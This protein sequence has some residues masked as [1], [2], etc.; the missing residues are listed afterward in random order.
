MKIPKSPILCVLTAGL[1]L[2]QSAGWSQ[3][4]S[5]PPGFGLSALAALDANTVVAVGSAILRT[6]D[7][8]ITWT[9]ASTAKFISAVSFCDA[10]TGSA[11]GAS[12]TILRTTDG[13]TTWTEQSSGTTRPLYGIKLL[14]ASIGVAVGQN[15]VILRTTDGG[16]TWN[17]VMVGGPDLWAISFADSQTGI[18]V[19]DMSLIRR[20]TD[21]GVTWKTLNNGDRLLGGIRAI[22]LT[23]G[24]TGIAMAGK[25]I[26][27]TT[28]GGLSWALHLSSNAFYGVFFTDPNTGAAVGFRAILRTTDG[29]VTWREQARI[30][31]Q[32]DGIEFSDALTGWAVGSKSTIFHTT[33]GGE[34][35]T[36][37]VS[38]ATLKTP[39]APESLASLRGSGLA[40]YSESADPK[41]PSTKLAGINVRV[42]D[43]TGAERLA[44]LS[45]V[46]PTRVDF[47]VPAGTAAG[48]AVLEVLHGDVTLPAVAAQVRSV[49]PGLFTSWGT[50]AA[51]YAVRIEADGRQTV[52]PAGSAIVLDDRPVNLVLFGTGIRNRSSLGNVR[53]TIGGIVVPV[54]YAGPGG[55]I[56]GL[57]QVNVHLTSALR[58]G[59]DGHLVLTVDGIV[60]NVVL[61]DVR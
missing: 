6:T 50:M 44:P 11:V 4:D 17:Q 10:R 39:L 23:D 15:G 59:A 53:C 45:Y 41:S 7:G 25:G 36:I 19:G 21:G 60:A 12:G 16:A 58:G 32:L 40:Y 38:S 1:G 20:T 35:G 13:G 3:L 26:L 49:S 47:V 37:A 34:P 42:R 46:S 51:A 22:S 14:D 52:L 30:V 48:D 43:S 55:D 24:D 2:A 31:N 61:V 33:T 56:P 29:G 57:D 5:V 28:D 9:V 8:G 54:E 27:R 18:A